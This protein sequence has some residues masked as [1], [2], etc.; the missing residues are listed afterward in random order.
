MNINSKFSAA[1]GI[2]CLLIVFT[3]GVALASP[4]D[5]ALGNGL[6]ARINTDKGDIVVRLEFQ[7]TPLTVCNFVAL[8]EGKMNVTGGK[9]F[10][11]GLVFHRVIADFMIQGGD[12]QGNGTGG[13]GYRFPDEIV[14]SLRHDG[15][16]VLSMANAGPG[17]NG[18]QFFITHKETPWLDGMHT[19]FGRVVEGQDV[20][21]AIR[22][23][24]RMRSITIIRNGSL[25]AQFKADQAAFDA[26]LK[27]NTLSAA[28]KAKSQRDSDI[29]EINAKYPGAIQTPSGIKYII[30]KQGTG[31]KPAAGKTAR[32]NYRGYLL[33][34]QVFDSTDMQGR[35]FEFPVGAGRVIRGW[36]ETVIDMKIG[37]KRLVIIPPELAYGERGAGNGAIPPNSFLIFEM[38]L[39][40]VR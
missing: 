12:P 22:Q 27:E 31:I 4:N 39:I 19:V 17:T 6:F 23:G 33:S 24:D 1:A 9:R 38:E 26:L 30:Q 34:G 20:V 5:A 37:E 29:A 3:A 8:A 18:S 15:P 32:V 14:P 11:D 16:G 21:N 13:P 28:G 36:D 35:P 7:K 40:G 2:G 25:A 10:Y